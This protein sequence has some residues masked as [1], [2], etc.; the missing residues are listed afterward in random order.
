MN[1]MTDDDLTVFAAPDGVSLR[2]RRIYAELGFALSRIER[3]ALA[4]WGTRSA[5]RLLSLTSRRIDGLAAIV[6]RVGRASLHEWRGARAASHQRRLSEHIGDRA[7][8]AI[9]GTISIGRNGLGVVTQ[10]AGALLR[11]PKAT[12]PALFG[13]LLGFGAGSG[14]LDGNG[15]IPD[16]DLL[17]D[18]GVHR[19]PVT[20][21]LVIGVLTEGL[22]LALADLAAQVHDNLPVSHDPMWDS[23]ARIG[24]P[25]THN[26]AV[27]A[28][29]GLAY[30]LMVDALIQPGALH[31]LPIELPMEAHQSILAASGLAEGADAANKCARRD[32]VVV[33]QGGA[34][35]PS[36]G[37]KVVDGVA[38]MAATAAETVQRATRGLFQRRG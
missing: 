24:G 19:S 37:R 30:H 5:T 23:L 34:P 17:V 22:A 14:G 6:A 36:T 35:E 12:A 10:V 29:A 2:A 15:G 32:P 26:L 28:S 8:V 21:T 33:V 7:A 9:D 31:G 18:I 11:D 25:L 27:G 4:G 13:A 3:D 16:L 20:H 38:D 1:T